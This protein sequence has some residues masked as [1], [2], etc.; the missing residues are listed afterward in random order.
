MNVSP[1]AR[2]AARSRGATMS[3]MAAQRLGRRPRGG[4]GRRWAGRRT[5]CR[6]PRAGRRTRSAG[7]ARAPRSWRWVSGWVLGEPVAVEVEAALVDASSSPRGRRGS[8]PAAGRPRAAAG[9][10]VGAGAPGRQLVEQLQVGVAAARLVAVDAAADPREGGLGRGDAG[11]RARPG[12]AA[13][14]SAAHLRA[15]RPRGARGARGPA[16]RPRRSG[17]AGPSQRPPGDERRAPGARPGRPRAGTR[18]SRAGL[19]ARA[20]SARPVT[21]ARTSAPRVG[22]RARRARQRGAG[23]RRRRAGRRPAAS[24]RL[25]PAPARRE[26]R[27]D[28]GGV[29]RGRDPALG[30]Q[31]GDQSRR[32][33][34]EGGVAHRAHRPGVS[35]APP[36]RRTSSA[37]RSSMTMPS[38][39][40]S[41]GSIDDVGPATTNGMPAAA[42]ASAWA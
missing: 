12:S 10:P 24:A 29:E 7:S 22:R 13:S 35:S 31:R 2:N 15:E 37:S 17:S 11:R 8:G 5:R 6:P 26:Q 27:A 40:G 25:T 14:R 34:V 19:A 18:R 28:R 30:H 38:P 21:P 3:S 33:H 20:P 4:P 9:A 36:A 41:A 1:R 42:A 32:R 39:S 23:R 16:C